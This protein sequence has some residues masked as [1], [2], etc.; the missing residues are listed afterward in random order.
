MD[1]F[2]IRCDGCTDVLTVVLGEASARVRARNHHEATGHTVRVKSAVAE[3]ELI[4]SAID[5]PSASL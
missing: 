5:W 1:S 2:L 4:I 3:A